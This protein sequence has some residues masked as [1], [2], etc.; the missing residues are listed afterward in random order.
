MRTPP[1]DYRLRV[2][3]HAAIFLVGFWPFWEPWLGLSARSTWLTLSAGI[4][5]QGWLN[6]QAATV[7]LLLIAILFTGLG[8]WVRVWG[9]AYLGV[10]V[11]TDPGMHA[12][13]LLADGP[14]R[15]V[16]NPL[17]LG[18]FLHTV[19]IAMLMPPAGSIFAIAAIW[20]L[21]VRLAMAEEP[22][23][24]ERFGPAYEQYK[25]S[26]PQFLPSA[27]ALVPPGG[28]RPRP[29]QAVAGE[30]YFIGV[31][32]TLVGFGWD[33]NAQPLIRGILIS[34]GASIVLQAFLPRAPKLVA[35]DGELREL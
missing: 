16:R 9:S 7:V 10:G 4:A 11:V 27:R 21:Q 5:R 33:F 30:I 28:A 31:V 35:G 22:F 15:H 2:P 17:Y 12:P 13:V 6:F 32:I 1:W 20:I 19:G 3:I 34:L 29:W 24:A 14:Y 26:V 18:T 23:L 8:A 25:T